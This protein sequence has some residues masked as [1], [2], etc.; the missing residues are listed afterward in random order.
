MNRPRVVVGASQVA[1]VVKNPPANAGDSRNEDSI[2]VLGRSAEKEM[3]TH[4]SIL[5]WESHGQRRLAGY[6]PWGCRESD[7]TESTLPHRV[8][9][10]IQ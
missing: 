6:S 2:P 9:V 10:R 5:A 8:V 3:L 4:S 7:M 1:I